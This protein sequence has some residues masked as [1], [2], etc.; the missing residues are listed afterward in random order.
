MLVL[1]HKKWLRLAKR[2]RDSSGKSY[3]ITSLA[4]V[5]ALSGRR[6]FRLDQALSHISSNSFTCFGLV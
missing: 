2:I 5:V 1:R 3:E 6:A 4:R